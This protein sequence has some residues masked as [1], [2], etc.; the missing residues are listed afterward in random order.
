MNFLI[1]IFIC[2]SAAEPINSPGPIPTE[3][4]DSAQLDNYYPDAPIRSLPPQTQFQ[5][6]RM[7][8]LLIQPNARRSKLY[9]HGSFACE[10][11]AE[12][13]NP[14]QLR[15]S[16]PKTVTTTTVT[17]Y[18]ENRVCIADRIPI[19]ESLNSETFDG[20]CQVEGAFIVNMTGKCFAAVNKVYKT[21]GC[22]L[23]VSLH[24]SSG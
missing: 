24:R 20:N 22:S 21:R 13:N 7:L 10:V 5:F 2:L 3:Y 1:Q 9:Y 12:Q 16:L 11:V 15:V 8:N 4:I 19:P 6:T 17:P 23:P 14:N 18:D